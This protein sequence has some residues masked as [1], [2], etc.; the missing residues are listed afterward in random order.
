MDENQ[1]KADISISKE[2][3]LVDEL[4][5]IQSNWVQYINVKPKL[6]KLTDHVWVVDEEMQK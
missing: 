1:E 2:I 4:G 3:G 6:D 5:H